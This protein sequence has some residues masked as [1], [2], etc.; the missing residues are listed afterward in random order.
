VPFILIS[1]YAKSGVVVHDTGDTGSVVKF[2]DMLYG[3]PALSTLPDERPFMPEGPRDADPRLTDL[4]GAFDP[5][6]LEGSASPIPASEAVIPDSAIST[7][8]APMNC[9]TLGMRPVSIP[10]ASLSPPAGYGPL[11]VKYI[12]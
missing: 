2:V 7:F 9:S 5:A 4:T 8:P 10:G 1:P 12:P 3:L 6:R 11:P